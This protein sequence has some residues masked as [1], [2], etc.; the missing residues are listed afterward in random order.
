MPRA[1]KPHSQRVGNLRNEK[2]VV[3]ADCQVWSRASGAGNS[4]PLCTQCPIS[5]CPSPT[6]SVS[7]VHTHEHHHG[8]AEFFQIVHV[9]D[10]TDIISLHEVNL[11]IVPWPWEQKG[12]MCSSD[13][14]LESSLGRV[15]M[16]IYRHRRHQAIFHYNPGPAWT[17]YIQWVSWNA[18]WFFCRHLPPPS[19]LHSMHSSSEVSK[20]LP[21]DR[22][23]S[24]Y[25]LMWETV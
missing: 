21:P 11:D 10:D 9:M 25:I 16:I 5:S 3:C 12:A 24:E 2:C 4:N 20:A 13:L 14:S 7:G 8:M 19:L 1:Y 17:Q 6:N 18:R 23:K 15:P 22:W